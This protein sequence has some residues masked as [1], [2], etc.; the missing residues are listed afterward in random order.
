MNI[1][2]LS[3]DPVEA[4]RVQCDQH[5]VKMILETAQM[6]STVAHQHKYL[7]VTGIYKPTHANHPMTKWVNTHKNN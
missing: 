5:V 3:K 6:L 1:F 4:A 2:F 7:G